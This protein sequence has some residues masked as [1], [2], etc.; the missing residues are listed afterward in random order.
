MALMSI[1]GFPNVPVFAIEL[2]SLTQLVPIGMIPTSECRN[3]WVK[4]VG[5]RKGRIVLLKPR[6]GE[7]QK[8]LAGKKVRE[9]AEE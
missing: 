9:M 2:L 6:L 4:A 5:Y 1:A 7:V 3:M 8:T